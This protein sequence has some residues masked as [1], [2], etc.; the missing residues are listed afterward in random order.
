MNMPYLRD[1]I[2]DHKPG[3]TKSEVWKI[4]ISMRVNFISSKDKEETRTI[5]VLS[6]NEDIMW[7]NE[8]DNI[9]KELFKSFLGNYQKEVQIMRG[10]SNFVFESVELMDYKLHKVSLKRGGSYLESHEWLVNKAGT[11]NQKNIKDNECF[12]YATVLSL[13]YN[14]IKKKELKN[15]FKKIKREDIDFLS[16]Q[17][18]C[19][20]HR[21]IMKK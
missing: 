10:G 13:N 14:E 8:T 16:H 19:N 21:K 3:E 6:D 11:I 7:G 18:V 17:K 5:Y 2:N 1:M 12:P 15:I 4:Q 20:F 9:I